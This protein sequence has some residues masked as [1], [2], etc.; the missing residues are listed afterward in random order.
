MMRESCETVS[1]T[2]EALAAGVGSE[3]KLFEVGEDCLVAGVAYAPREDVVAWASDQSRVFRLVLRPEA[4][5][6][7]RV[8]VER[9][10]VLAELS[11]PGDDALRAGEDR[12]LPMMFRG[13]PWVLNAR[14]GDSL[15]WVSED[16]GGEG[17]ADPG[18]VVKVLIERRENM[19]EANIPFFI[20]KTIDVNYS[21]SEFLLKGYGPL[22]QELDET[23]SQPTGRL[24]CRHCLVGDA[25]FEPATSAV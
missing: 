19:Y 5:P 16:A 4:D 18:G 17:L 20:W 8:V 10:L 13:N 1:A 24:I 22:L 11:V 14:E 7:S 3:T 21:R 15:L 12:V 25:G 23:P 9:R 6:D 2:T